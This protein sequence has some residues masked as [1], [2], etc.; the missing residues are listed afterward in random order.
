MADKFPQMSKREKRALKVLPGPAVGHVV[1]APP[2]LNAS[3]H[4]IDYVCGKCGT[5]LLQADAGQVHGVLIHC[6]NCG[7]YNTTDT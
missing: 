2:V 4:T 7:T 5:V 6:T 3:D 1:D